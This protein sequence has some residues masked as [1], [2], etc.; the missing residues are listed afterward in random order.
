[1]LIE[2]AKDISVNPER[3][4]SITR[5][6]R[7]SCDVLMA[8]GECY[9]AEYPYELMKKRINEKSESL[10][11]TLRNIDLNTQSVRA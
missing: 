9:T 6:G 4:E 3:I 10:T 5:K 11:R 7:S 1:M 8:S 2:I